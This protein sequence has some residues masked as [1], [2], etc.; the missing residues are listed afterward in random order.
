[1]IVV[2]NHSGIGNRI[3]NVVSALRKGHLRNDTVQVNFRHNHLFQFLQCVVTPRPEQEVSNTWKLEIL[4]E[5]AG[6]PLLIEPKP[7]L[8]VHDEKQGRF[9]N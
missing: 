8:I 5:D 7:F 9:Q 3:K 6:K 4:P 1:M 2:V